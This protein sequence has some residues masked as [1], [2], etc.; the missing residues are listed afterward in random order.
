MPRQ[1][2]LIQGRN[3]GIRSLDVLRQPENQ[4]CIRL[5]RC[6]NMK[7]GTQSS[8]QPAGHFG[9]RDAAQAD[10]LKD[11]PHVF[12]N[13]CSAAPPNNAG[14]LRHQ[15]LVGNDARKIARKN[16]VYPIVAQNGAR[17]GENLA[18]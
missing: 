3:N 14:G 11:R 7:L 8:L 5:W 15:S 13:V 6:R 9:R 10:I 12:G 17:E 2:R 4:N 16:N 18:R 1:T